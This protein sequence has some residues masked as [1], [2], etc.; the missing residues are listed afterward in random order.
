MAKPPA[1]IGHGAVDRAVKA[2][3]KAGFKPRVVMDFVNGTM[4]VEPANDA[5][6]Q[7]SGWQER[8][9]DRV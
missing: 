9:P 3:V 2:L 7:L 1:T 8:A 5:E 6:P 4:T